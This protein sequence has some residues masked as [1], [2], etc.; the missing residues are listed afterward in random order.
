MEELVSS[1]AEG[2]L[3]QQLRQCRGL[4]LVATDFS[5]SHRGAPLG[6]PEHTREGYLAA[7]RMGAGLIECDAVLT[8][9]QRLVCRHSECD[10]HRTTNVLQTELAGQCSEPFQPWQT[11]NR[12]TAKCCT[13]DFT[14]DQ[15]KRLCGRTD[16]VNERAVSVD[17]YLLPKE[18]GA[19]SFEGDCGTLV[20]H[21]ESIKLISEAGRKFIP[22]LKGVGR[23]TLKKM[24]L[25]LSEYASLLLEDY[26]SLGIDPARVFPQSFS[27]EIIVHWLENHPDYRERL[28][29]LDGRGRSPEFKAS[30]EDMYRLRSK[31]LRIL[32]PP[33][34]MLLEA[35][36][37]GVLNRTDY[38]RYAEAA[39]F[40]LITWTFESRLS[41]LRNFSVLPSDMLKVLEALHNKVK[42]K[43]VFSDWPETVT[44]YANCFGLE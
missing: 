9:D 39:G 20:S 40:D 11:N 28:V 30:L 44:A 13:S 24:G 19:Y 27:L 32:A 43:G 8:Q 22:E 18:R 35:N 1:L 37:S 2:P 36:A 16:H 15:I 29:F 3:R 10:L 34:P 4:P 25:S 31:G 26:T 17:D 14:L 38:A 41:V 33:I 42:V 21:K 6:Y 23:S 7:I 12:A 5:I